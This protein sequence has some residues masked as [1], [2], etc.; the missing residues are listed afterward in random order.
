MEVCE[1]CGKPI[2][3]ETLKE[4]LEHSIVAEVTI[5]VRQTTSRFIT[6]LDCGKYLVKTYVGD[7]EEVFEEL[8]PLKSERIYTKVP[9]RKTE[10]RA[11]FP[12]ENVPL[13]LRSP[14]SIV[15]D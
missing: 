9:N 12:P 15:V 10:F 11:S 1:C 7:F 14:C 13:S 6:K 2:P 5:G 4:I 8:I 3:H